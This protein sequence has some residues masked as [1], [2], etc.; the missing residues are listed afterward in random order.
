[1]PVMRPARIGTSRHSR[2][3][4]KPRTKSYPALR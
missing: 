3:Y 4:R 2:W 1:L